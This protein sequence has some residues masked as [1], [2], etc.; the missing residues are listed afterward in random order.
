MAIEKK[1]YKYNYNFGDKDIEIKEM[2]CYEDETLNMTDVFINNHGVY[3]FY[4][5]SDSRDNVDRFLHQIS[6]ILSKEMRVASHLYY[7][8]S[9]R[10][11][12]F[13]AFWEEYSKK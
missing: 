7:L 4:M 3:A 11:N 10:F 9:G 12:A 6:I 13:N 1:Y 2:D 8:A 5:Y